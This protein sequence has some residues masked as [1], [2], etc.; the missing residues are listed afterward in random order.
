[1]CIRDLF[2]QDVEV[3]F[4]VCVSRNAL[5]SFVRKL[6]RLACQ[7][8]M[9]ILIR[10]FNFSVVADSLLERAFSLHPR[11]FIRDGQLWRSS[12]SWQGTITAALAC[13]RFRI[14]VRSVF[15]DDP[16]SLKLSATQLSGKSGRTQR[17]RHHF[18]A[19]EA[20][21]R[22]ELLGW[23]ILATCPQTRHDAW[24]VRLPGPTVVVRLVKVSYGIDVLVWGDRAQPW[25][26]SLL[27]R[28]RTGLT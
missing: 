19:R 27:G 17:H 1:M 7:D 12:D 9:A 10:D 16:G 14:L 18:A 28:N 4:L 20:E 22:A 24:I 25:C 8:A 13:R 15:C 26:I 6:S 11:F 21:G 23:N 5:E 3:I 2:V